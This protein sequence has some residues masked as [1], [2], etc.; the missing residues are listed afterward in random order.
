MGI[1]NIF[2]KETPKEK[3]I[4]MFYSDYPEKP[5]ISDER[6]IKDWIERAQG[7]PKQ[8]L[9]DKKMMKRFSDGLLPGHVYMLYWLN[10]YTN[11]KVPA[12]FEYKYGVDFEKEKTFLLENGYLNELNKPTEKGTLAISA[13]QSVIN[14]HAPKPDRSI[15]AISKQTLQQLDGIKRNGFKHYTFIA[16][17]D[18]CELCANLNGKHFPISRLKIG[19]NAPPMHEGCRCSIAAYEND[20]NYEEWLNHL[21]KGGATKKWNKSKK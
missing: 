9:V 7:M 4:R 1:F 10:K 15:E 21:Q 17:R 20:E 8:C 2:K 18:C 5:F 12:Y 19:K 11:K 14:E 3:V 6:D 13:H 16:N